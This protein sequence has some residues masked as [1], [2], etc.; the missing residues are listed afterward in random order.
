[1]NVISYECITIE[2]KEVGCTCGVHVIHVQIK[3]IQ[4]RASDMATTIIDTSWLNSM[5]IVNRAAFSAC[6][7]RT[8]NKFINEILSNVDDTV[9]TDFGEIMISDTAQCVLNTNINHIKIPLADLIK[10]RVSGNGGFDFHTESHNQNIVYGEA[11]YSG[12]STRY[13]DAL[14][15]INEFISDG[16]DIAELVTLQHFVSKEAAENAI[17]GK[18][19]FTAAFSMKCTN[20]KTIFENALKS[21]HLQALLVYDE[22]YL[23]GVEVVCD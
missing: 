9:N 6:A 5:N 1:M 15:Q 8:I 23:I 22:I 19:G 18:K 3:D 4:K 16:K 20:P 14:S 17:N 13:N 2:N 21:E 12:N 11:K 7:E 10:E